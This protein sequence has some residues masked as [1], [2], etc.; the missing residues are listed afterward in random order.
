MIDYC[1]EAFTMA[2]FCTLNGPTKF[3]NTYSTVLIY[4]YIGIW[5]TSETAGKTLGIRTRLIVSPFYH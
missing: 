2:C 3:L 4:D 5:T 1:A